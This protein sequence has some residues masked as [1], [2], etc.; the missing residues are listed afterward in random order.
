[1]ANMN[2]GEQEVI[3]LLRNLKASDMSVLEA[4][5]DT[6]D[7]QIATVRD[8]PNDVLWSAL[9]RMGLA[10]EM[11]LDI[12]IPSALKNFYPKSFAFTE[13]GRAEMPRLLRLA[14]GNGEADR[15]S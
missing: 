10:Q 3:D 4:T 12:E 5:L 2:A 13:R 15:V 14:V 8:S 7:S 11:V 6:P 9:E 1:M